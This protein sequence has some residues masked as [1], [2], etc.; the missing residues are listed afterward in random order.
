MG[1]RFSKN[2]SS[3]TSSS[4]NSNG[5]ILGSGIFGLFGTKII[6]DSTDNST[7]CNFM[8]FFNLLIVFGMIFFIL[9][10]LY[11]FLHTSKKR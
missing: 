3:K 9:Y 6:C 8:K 10:F 11:L 1:K 5:G 4:N 7:Y 2:S